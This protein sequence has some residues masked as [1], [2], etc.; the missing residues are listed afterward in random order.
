MHKSYLGQIDGD[1]TCAEFF[2]QLEVILVAVE[3][4]MKATGA[5][6]STE[7]FD[8][9]QLALA[10]QKIMLATREALKEV[11]STVQD[12]HLGIMLIDLRL[13]ALVGNIIMPLPR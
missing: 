7:V 6:V 4:G 11:D 8:R 13:R 5:V 10:A 1:E 2:Y 12:V 9:L 3:A